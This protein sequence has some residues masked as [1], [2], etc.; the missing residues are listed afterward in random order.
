MAYLI[1]ILAL[2]VLI[3]LWAYKNQR[4]S[5]RFVAA[6]AAVATL[7]VAAVPLGRKAWNH[8]KKRV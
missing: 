7:I 8:R 6:Y 5:G 3:A 1:V 4:V 2:G